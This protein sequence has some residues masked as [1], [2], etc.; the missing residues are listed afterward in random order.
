MRKHNLNAY[1]R[2]YTFTN[3]M[4]AR[5]TKLHTEKPLLRVPLLPL[6]CALAFEVPYI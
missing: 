6:I 4:T 1:I 5:I 2:I 3:I